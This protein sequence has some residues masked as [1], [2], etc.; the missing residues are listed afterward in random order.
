MAADYGGTSDP[1]VVV[2]VAGQKKQTAIVK[3]SLNPVFNAHFEFFN[4]QLYDVVAIKVSRVCFIAH[5]HQVLKEAVALAEA[6][7]AAAPRC[8][9]ALFCLVVVLK[10]HFIL[11]C[12]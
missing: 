4:V 10:T 6:V 9:T 11:G 5:Q 1:Y 7:A 3:Q 8:C 12:H 2:T